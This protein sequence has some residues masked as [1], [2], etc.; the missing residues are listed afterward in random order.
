M[1]GDG[2]GDGKN[3][4]IWQI[5][6][7]KSPAFG[8]SFHFKFNQFDVFFYSLWIYSAYWKFTKLCFMYLPRWP[9]FNAIME[10]RKAFQ[11]EGH[12]FEFCCL[13][14]E[15]V[16]FQWIA[17]MKYNYDTNDFTKVHDNFEPNKHFQGWKF[18]CWC[19]YISSGST[20]GS[21]SSV[22]DK[23]SCAVFNRYL[24]KVSILCSPE[25]INFPAGFGA[26]RETR[27]INSRKITPRSCT[28]AVRWGG[29]SSWPHGYWGTWALRPLYRLAK[30]R[31]SWLWTTTWLAG[32]CGAELPDHFHWH[33]NHRLI[34]GLPELMNDW[35]LLT[36]K[37]PLLS[38]TNGLMHKMQI[39]S[40]KQR[41]K[42]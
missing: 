40:T 38:F 35:L 32:R 13:I 36:Y 6:T 9:F 10:S 23:I 15:M 31:W 37:P 27:D 1:T 28:W 41:S 17:R 7:V 18:E 4:F 11:A 19:Q 8:C 24:H 20:V 16:V 5:L 42:F 34:H 29:W 14:F 26:R 21:K 12:S 2:R 22:I 33:D 3:R 25:S 39:V 30:T